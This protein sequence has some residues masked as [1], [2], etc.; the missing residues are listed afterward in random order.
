MH[1]PMVYY[2]VWILTP[3]VPA[4]AMFKWL[5]SDVTATGPFKGMKWKL[6]TFMVIPPSLN[7][8]Q[9]RPEP[10]PSHFMVGAI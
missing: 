8:V 10:C 4:Y 9:A 6:V 1:D 3:V 5:P 2:F 7:T